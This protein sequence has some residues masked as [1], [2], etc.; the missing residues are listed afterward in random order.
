[1]YRTFLVPL[2]GSKL[3]E[4][5]LPYAVKLA[6]AGRGR[7]I[8]IRVAIAPPPMTIDGL[9]WESSQREAVEEAERYLAAVASGMPSS[10]AVE[11]L[12]PYGRTEKQ[13]LEVVSSLQVS[14]IVMA[15]H[16]RTG[17]PHLLHGSVAEGILAHSNVPVLLVHAR[18]GEQVNA[19][20]DLVAS[21][22]MVPLDGSALAE[23]ALEPAGQMVSDG[24]ELVLLR[25]VQFPEDVLTGDDGRVIAYV[26]QQ[27]EARKLAALDML[28]AT[29]RKLRD[30][31]PTVNVTTDARIGTPAESIVAA[32]ADHQV[33]LIVM[34]THGRTGLGRAVL[35]SVAGEVLRTAR[36]PL[37]LLHAQSAPT[38]A[39]LVAV[40]PHEV[41]P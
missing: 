33:S 3:A 22:L 21:R 12:V 24:G 4:R 27:A 7:L 8:L 11:T 41:A 5:A 10:L 26:D 19:E 38:P 36:V 6:E 28:I 9:D 34:A 17:L 16:G 29:A 30:R 13:I 35:G 37:L 1:M 14:V 2:D 32:A 15:T 18:P 23:S 25:V 39:P 20:L 40:A 31:F